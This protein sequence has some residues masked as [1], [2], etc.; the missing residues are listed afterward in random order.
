M[1]TEFWEDFSVR[2]VAENEQD[3]A[4]IFA[5]TKHVNVGEDDKG[6]HFKFLLNEL[7]DNKNHTEV[8]L[9]YFGENGSDNPWEELYALVIYPCIVP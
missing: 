8:D 5:Y 6:T 1:K 9:D 3:K 4:W 2:L 7:D